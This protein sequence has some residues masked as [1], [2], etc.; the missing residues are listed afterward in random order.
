MSPAS[1][2]R[3]TRRSGRGVALV[4]AAIVTPLLLGLIFGIIEFGFVF[5][6]KLTVSNAS[7]A[8]ARA[9]S[10][11]GSNASA[12]LQI[13]RAVGASSGLARVEKVVVYKAAS[14]TDPVPAGCTSSPV[15]IAG[16]CNVYDNSDL[17]ISDAA[18]GDIAYSK[19]TYWPASSRVTSVA[20]PTGPDFL[21]VWV[22][23]RHNSAFSSIVPSRLLSDAVVMRLEPTR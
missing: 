3:E 5:K 18:F 4:E 1:K 9:G 7:R 16:V 23:V 2:R 19:N 15:G 22:Q 20:A 11:A 14:S 13:L 10:A 6:D 21:G 12:D 8:G 17:T